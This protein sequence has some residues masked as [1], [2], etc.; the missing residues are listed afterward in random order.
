MRGDSHWR[1]PSLILKKLDVIDDIENFLAVFVHVATQHKWPQEISATQL[2]GLLTDKAMAVY[3]AL[4]AADLL[5]Y[6]ITKAA[7]L[8]WYDM[9]VPPGQEAK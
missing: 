7:I 6:E 9:N 2:A 3:T 4:S 1:K 5:D 8:H